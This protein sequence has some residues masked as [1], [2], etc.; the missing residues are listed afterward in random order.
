M[1]PSIAGMLIPKVWYGQKIE[2]W[3]AG[4]AAGGGTI[5][6]GGAARWLGS[7][8]SSAKSQGCKPR[9]IKNVEMR[10]CPVLHR[11]VNNNSAIKYYR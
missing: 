8:A 6:A 7:E 11:N 2:R 1:A 5:S 4:R 10:K 9:L 3:G